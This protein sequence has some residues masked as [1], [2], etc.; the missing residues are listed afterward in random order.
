GIPPSQSRRK[1]RIVQ[2]SWE[3]PIE[4]EAAERALAEMREIRARIDAIDKE[5]SELDAALDAITG[6]QVLEG[7]A[8]K[9]FGEQVVF[10]PLPDRT[11]KGAVLWTLSEHA[12]GMIALDL[13]AEVNRRLGTSYQRTSLSPQLSRLKS[14]GK[15]ILEGNVWKLA[16]TTDTAGPA[17]WQTNINATAMEYRHMNQYDLDANGIISPSKSSLVLLFARSLLFSSF[18]DNSSSAFAV[19]CTIMV[20]YLCCQSIGSVTGS[21][22]GARSRSSRLIFLSFSVTASHR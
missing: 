8:K 14:E 15:I 13:L 18:N 10:K 2:A 16:P 4:S 1:N 20:V 12:D 19:N 5:R 9:V 7:F 22:D 17:P 6:Q 3:S 11:I 21:D